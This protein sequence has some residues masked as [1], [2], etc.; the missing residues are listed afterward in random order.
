MRILGVDPGTLNM[1]YGVVDDDGDIKLVTC[2]VVSV[3]SKIPIEQRLHTL[4]IGICQIISKYNPDE[5]AVEEPF[6]ATNVR[7]ALAIG[8]AQAVIILSAV[9][10]HLPIFRYSPNIIK[11]QVTNNGHSSKEQVIEMVKLQLR[12]LEPL[13]SNDAADALAIA[14]C[15]LNISHY[16]KMINTNQ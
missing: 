4:Y 2:G 15:H 8:R 11:Q 5:V 3:T 10:R 13:K 16:Q 12:Q 7:T 1:G 9:E 14:L 6:V